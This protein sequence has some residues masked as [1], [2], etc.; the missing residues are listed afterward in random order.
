M[1]HYVYQ[2]K[3]YLE[4]AVPIFIWIF[5]FPY[6]DEVNK[7]LRSAL[8]HIKLSGEGVYVQASTLGSLEA[9]LEFLRT[10]KIPVSH[11]NI[12]DSISAFSVQI[13]TKNAH[14][15]KKCSF[16]KVDRADKK[17]FIYRDLSKLQMESRLILHIP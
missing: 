5:F 3:Y 1:G 9:L 15:R 10:S 7:E 17:C 4:I 2:I 14:K 6:S 13:T 12:S 11:S 8:S 16:W